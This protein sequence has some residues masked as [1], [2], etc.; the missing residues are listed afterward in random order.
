MLIWALK[1][2]NNDFLGAKKNDIGKKIMAHI[3]IV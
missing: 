2:G 3:G 1:Y